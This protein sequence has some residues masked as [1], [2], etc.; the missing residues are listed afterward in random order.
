MVRY[1]EIPY[2]HNGKSFTGADCWGFVVLY[3]ENTLGTQLRDYK[4]IIPPAYADVRNSDIFLDNA[5]TE[6][7]KVETLRE[8]DCIL[9]NVDSKTP[10]HVAIYIGNGKIIHMIHPAGV[11][12]S[13]LAEWQSK[14][15]GY[16]RYRGVN[17]S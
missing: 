12:V 5:E 10:N 2:K 11:V 15:H 13:R 8:N 9:L 3:F 17:A 4:D 16:Y 14:V 7:E 6:F 1:F